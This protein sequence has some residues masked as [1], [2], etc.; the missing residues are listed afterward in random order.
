MKTKL[1]CIL[2][3]DDDN[4]C[5]F[6]HK[7]LL[8]GMNCTENIQVATNGAEALDFLKTCSENYVPDI[9]LLDI[10]MPKVNGWEFLEAYEK[11]PTQ[12]KAKIVLIMLTTSLNPDDR[13]KA[14]TFPSVKGF[15]EKYLDEDMLQDILKEHFADH[16]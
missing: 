4:D 8:Q 6:F 1:N 10:N 15:K 14:S 2:L 12:F 13:V 3:V 9:I 5:N 7:R 16:F 11:L